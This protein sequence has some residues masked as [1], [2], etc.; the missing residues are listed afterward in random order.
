MRHAMIRGPSLTWIRL[1]GCIV[2]TFGYHLRRR[3]ITG[4]T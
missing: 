2:T 3:Q 1:V 4:A